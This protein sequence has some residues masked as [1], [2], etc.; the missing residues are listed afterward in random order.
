MPIIHRCEHCNAKLQVPSRKAGQ[1]VRCPKCSQRTTIP[2]AGDAAAAKPAKPK[3]KTPKGADKP[4]VAKIVEPP[5]PERE[6]KPLV[7][8]VVEAPL[9][10]K[11]V[12][13]EQPLVANVV[14]PGSRS[15]GVFVDRDVLA[16]EFASLE[17]E[18]MWTDP[19]EDEGF[20]LSRG[21][22]DD[23]EM[24][25][26]PMVDV[27]FLL[28]IFFMITAS[29]SLQ[30]TINV[31]PPDPDEQAATQEIVE[32]E[33]LDDYSVIVEIDEND[34]LIVDDEPVG[35]AELLEQI[36][37]E[38]AAAEDKNEVVIQADPLS[39]HDVN[40]KVIDAA[41]GAEMSKIRIA[42]VAGDG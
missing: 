3:S 6:E 38:K 15:T 18:N 12:E 8:K 2:E 35:S 20:Q 26:T 37:R 40:V 10:A 14:E 25:L 11:V 29:F 31:P 13:P 22:P 32:L 17:E 9:V 24:D 28:L 5:A 27:T 34:V 19:G 21:R 39:S 30:K 41:T 1:Q 42:T 7:A 36:F 33:E 4:L 16:R 23:E